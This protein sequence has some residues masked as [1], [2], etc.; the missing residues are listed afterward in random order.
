MR[1]LTQAASLWLS[2]NSAPLA[3]LPLSFLL[4]S[5]ILPVV[6]VLIIAA[7]GFIFALPYFDVLHAEARKSLSKVGGLECCG[8]N[9]I[10]N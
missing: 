1:L 2:H 4:M 7:T 8:G 10:N 9:W 5:S 3:A 6:K